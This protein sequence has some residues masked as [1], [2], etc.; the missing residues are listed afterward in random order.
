MPWGFAVSISHARH[1]QL[2]AP[3]SW[4]AKRLLFAIQCYGT[5]CPLDAI[6]V[7]LDPAVVEEAHQTF[8]AGQPV[9][10]RFGNGALLRDREQPF[11]EPCLELLHDYIDD[12][13]SP[14]PSLR[15]R[16]RISSKSPRPA[17][18]SAIEQSRKALKHIGMPSMIGRRCI[19][20]K[21][22][23]VSAADPDARAILIA[24]SIVG[25]SLRKRKAPHPKTANSVATINLS[26]SGA[27]PALADA[28]PRRSV[29][30]T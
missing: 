29:T 11:L 8:P 6:G 9:A 10:D 16:D 18:P 4:P 22:S 12:D 1:A 20:Q 23:K 26:C 7:H 2:T 25:I 24:K 15:R 28:G 30:K 3:S 14:A 13:R 17:S 27:R 21:R 19:H 5:H